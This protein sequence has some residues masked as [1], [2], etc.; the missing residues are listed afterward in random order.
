MTS[1][2]L[3]TH[4]PRLE[5]LRKTVDSLLPQVDVV[6]IYFNECDPPA[7]ATSNPNIHVHSSPVNLTDNGKFYFL[8]HTEPNEIYFTCDDD[9]IYP[10][11]YVSTTLRWLE[12]CPIVSYH[13]KRINTT[14]NYQNSYYFGGHYVF[15]YKATTQKS[16]YVHIPGTGV[17]AIDLSKYKPT[18]L[19]AHAAQRKMSDL[20]FAVQAAID[21]QAIL[22]PAHKSDWFKTTRNETSIC[23]DSQRA[24]QT[25]HVELIKKLIYLHKIPV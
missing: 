15:D 23:V 4:A 1:A 3:A 24:D 21:N 2:N 12:R 10:Q 7:W 11:D 25:K 5:S 22:T 17:M 13:G 6:R 19:I 14:G 20:V 9:I 8:D 18:Q 16:E